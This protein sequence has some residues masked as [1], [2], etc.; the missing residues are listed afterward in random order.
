MSKVRHWERRGRKRS[1]LGCLEIRDDV[2]GIN[3]HDGHVNDNYNFIRLRKMINNVAQGI[4]RRRNHKRD[5]A[6]PSP[7]AQRCWQS[8]PA[9][10]PARPAAPDD[11]KIEVS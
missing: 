2:S 5:D 1:Q 10:S 7:A 3:N 8:F 6:N 9:A 11:R 4:N